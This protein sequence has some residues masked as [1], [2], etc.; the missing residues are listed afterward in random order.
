MI[1]KKK[2]LAHFVKLGIEIW[3]FVRKIKKRVGEEMPF[4]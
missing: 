4:L 3:Y 1:Y 2:Y